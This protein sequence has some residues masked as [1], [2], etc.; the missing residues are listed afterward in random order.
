MQASS[1]IKFFF[2]PF[3]QTSFGLPAVFLKSFF[4]RLSVDRYKD[5]PKLFKI[6]GTSCRQAIKHVRQFGWKTDSQ[7]HTRQFGWQADSQKHTRQL[8]WQTDRQSDKQTKPTVAQQ[9]SQQWQR[10][11]NHERR[12]S[13]WW[14][15]GHSG[16][17]LLSHPS[18]S[19]HQAH[20][21]CRWWTQP[22]QQ[23]YTKPR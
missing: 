4:C 7:M 6:N 21:L 19:E 17:A 18:V 8:S 22:L 9:D 11:G 1:S 16:M 2:N 10:T 20:A 13:A 3:Y 5:I 14:R 23:S 12:Q 15:R